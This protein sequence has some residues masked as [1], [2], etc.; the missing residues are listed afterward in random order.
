MITHEVTLEELGQARTKAAEMGRLRNSILGGAGN[1][2]GF[3]GEIIAHNILGGIWANTYDYDLILP[4]GKTVDAKTKQ[5]SVIPKSDYAC[6]V[7]A[8]N[9]KQ[10][11]DYYAFLRVKND[12]TTGWFFGIV[13]KDW[14]FDNA[15]YREKG[16]VEPNGFTI[17]ASCYTIPISAV[18]DYYEK[19]Y[20][21]P[22][23]KKGPVAPS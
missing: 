16:T 10:K 12:L 14:F 11:C 3:V 5:T 18:E 13:P 2:A 19:E 15:Q 20:K 9:T 8:Y 17:R 21:P 23:E 1:L 7:A 22:K 6:N 4:D